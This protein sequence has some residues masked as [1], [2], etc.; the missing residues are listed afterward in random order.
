MKRFPRV[1]HNGLAQRVRQTSVVVKMPL[2]QNSCRLALGIGVA[3]PLGK[4]RVIR[5]N[6]YKASAAASPVS[7][8]PSINPCHSSERCSPANETR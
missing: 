6:N 2:E 5:E 8:A 7:I 4:S 3:D 1:S